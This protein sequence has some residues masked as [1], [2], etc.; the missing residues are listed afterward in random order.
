MSLAG[1]RTL[2]ILN[3]QQ[4]SAGRYTCI[5]TNEAGETL[6]HYEVKV[7]SMAMLSVLDISFYFIFLPFSP[8][9]VLM[10]TSFP[11]NGF[12]E[13]TSALAPGIAGGKTPGKLIV[14]SFAML[15]LH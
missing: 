13:Q 6:R 15:Q 8:L 1:G 12:A 14:A 9:S 5:A 11:I 4:D 3:A 2:Q 10:N 7:Y